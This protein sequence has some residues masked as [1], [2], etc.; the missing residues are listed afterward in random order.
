M[1]C[2]RI[3]MCYADDES[4]RYWSINLRGAKSPVLYKDNYPKSC[5]VRLR[6]VLFPSKNWLGNRFGG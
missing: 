6:S 3:F 5:K 4:K 2:N 1:I